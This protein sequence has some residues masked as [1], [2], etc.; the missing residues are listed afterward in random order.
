[1][2][3]PL[4]WILIPALS[5]VVMLVLSR[6]QRLITVL[7]TVIAFVLAATAWLLPVRE[8]FLLGPLTINFTD[9]WM[10]LG[11]RF[12]LGPA[13]RSSLVILYLA[14]AF[15]FGAAYVVHTSRLFVPLGLAMVSL[16]TAAL[17]VEPFLFAAL[18]IEI[19][20]LVSVPL[21]TPPDSQVGSGIIR[22]I[23]L[24][25]LGMPFILFAGWMMSSVEIDQVVDEQFLLR[26]SFL[27]GLG[28]ALQLGIFPFHSWVPMLGKESHPYAAAF[29][30]TMVPGA[31]TLIVLSLF[32][33]LP[34][35]VATPDVHVLLRVMGVVMV[36]FAGLWAAFQNNL[37]SMLGYAAILEIGLSLVLIGL[38][39][40]DLES[41]HLGV[42]YAMLFPRGLGLGLWALALAVIRTRTGSL[43]FIDIQGAGRILPITTGALVLAQFSLAGLPLL[44]SFPIRLPMWNELAQVSPTITILA[45][46]G[47]MGLLF[48]GIRTL[49]VLVTGSEEQSW[50][51][52]ETRGEI[53]FLATGIILLLIWGLFPQLILPSIANLPFKF[54]QLGS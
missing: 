35:F 14:A 16:L 18:L 54:A 28:F 22:Y 15:F 27:V 23:T 53:I 32:E 52:S 47:C 13:D 4:V 33:R 20:V 19:A 21:L 50:R 45:L 17:A 7:G 46:I 36:V 51:F 29:V 37:G 40:G 5:S 30:F 1:M 10:V 9:T 34:W 43:D 39:A 49:A 25:T 42:F 3:A 8:Q 11:R 6:W 12:V 24:L 2:S 48:G 31:I 41:E 44:A 26:A 38:I